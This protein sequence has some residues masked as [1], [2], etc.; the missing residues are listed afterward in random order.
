[1]DNKFFWLPAR[2]LITAD[3]IDL[4]AKYTYVEHRAKGFDMNWATELYSKHIEAFSAGLYKETGQPLKNSLRAYIDTF[5]ELIESI[6]YGE[7]DENKSVIPVSKEAKHILDGAHRVA[8]SAY[9]DKKVPCIFEDTERKYDYSFFK[10]QL[11]DSFYL[12]YIATKYVEWKKQDIYVF[13]IWPKGYARKDLFLKADK[14]IKSHA[15]IVYEKDIRINY[16]GLKNFM[17]QIYPMGGWSG[18]IDNHFKGTLGKVDSVYDPAE[19]VHAYIVES[20]NSDRM[21]ELKEEIRTIFGIDKSSVYSS[22]T[23]EE[24]LRMTHLLFNV[25][26]VDLLNNGKIDYDTE[27]FKKLLKLQ[28]CIQEK[29]INAEEVIIDSSGILGMYGIRKCRDIDYLTINNNIIKAIDKSVADCHNDLIEY[30]EKSLSDIIMNPHNYAYVLDVKFITLPVLKTFT[31]N[32]NEAKDI[33]D[34]KLINEKIRKSISWKNKVECRIIKIKRDLRNKR[35]HIRDSLHGKNI[36][37]FTKMWHFIRGKG[38]KL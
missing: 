32:R 12:D 10:S 18:T 22:D 19:M 36:Y 21:L 25:N 9:F 4:M 1:M 37:V 3:R 16:N 35:T 28:E 6:G 11:L 29:N 23:F 2:N 14:H 31:Q 24:A 38:F 15:D 34:V 27:L 17:I 7:F 5:D 20:Y 33:E 30:Y 8:V 26:S 13:I